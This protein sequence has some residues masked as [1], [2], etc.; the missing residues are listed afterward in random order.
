MEAQIPYSIGEI[1]TLVVS[2]LIGTLAFL[3]FAIISKKR[4]VTVFF[5]FLVLVI[6]LFVTHIF[7]EFLKLKNWL[8]W[9][10]IGQPIIAF[11]G[12]Y[13][14]EWFDKRYLKIFDSASNKFGLK[15]NEDTEQENRE[16]TDENIKE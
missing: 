2:T 13:I 6:N 12:L 3:A 8:E 1:I 7:S 4:K 16:E 9:K 14:L 11:A 15:I 10:G 5:A